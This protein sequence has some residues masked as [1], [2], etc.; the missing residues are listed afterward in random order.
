MKKANFDIVIDADIARA[1]GTSEH[2]ISKSCRGL[3]ESVMDNDHSV[4]MC[5]TL[6]A[7]WKKHRSMFATRWLASMTARKRVK[8]ITPHTVTTHLINTNI[9][10]ERKAKIALKDAHLVDA[11][12]SS[13]EII[14]SNDDNAR[15]VFCELTQTCGNL[16]SVKWFNCINDKQILNNFLSTNCFVPREYYL[17]SPKE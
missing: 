15:N 3:L 7:E 16:K 10:N 14:A 5:P 8:R 6:T 9:N 17:C 12:L 1:S 13:N 11:A 2:P 4:T